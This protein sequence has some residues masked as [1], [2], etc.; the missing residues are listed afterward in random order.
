MG[1][2]TGVAMSGWKSQNK[3]PS[4]PMRTPKKDSQFQMLDSLMPAAVSHVYIYARTPSTLEAAGGQKT[5][6]ILR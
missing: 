6:A 1:C 5:F 2:L 3:D 4:N